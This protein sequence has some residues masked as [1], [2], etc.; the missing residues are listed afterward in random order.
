MAAHDFSVPDPNLA[1]F[2][3][4][5]QPCFLC[6]EDI[7]LGMT[8]YWHGMG[9]RAVLWLHPAC[10]QELGCHLISDALRAKRVHDGMRRRA[11]TARIVGR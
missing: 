2:I 8:V 11:A 5:P 9:R 1:R 6:G 4:E 3:G 10:A 7:P